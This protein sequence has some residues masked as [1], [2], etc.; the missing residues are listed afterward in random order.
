MKQSVNDLMGAIEL[1]IAELA[2]ELVFTVCI[3]SS[4]MSTVP[5]EDWMDFIEVSVF[6]KAYFIEFTKL[7]IC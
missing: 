2:T 3:P 7:R 6:L 1:E 4:S 5:N